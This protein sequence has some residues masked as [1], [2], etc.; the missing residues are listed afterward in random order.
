MRSYYRVMLGK[1]SLYAKECVE[2]GFIGTDYG[3]RQDLTEKLPEDWREFNREFIPIYQQINNIQSK[4]SAGLACGAL[5]TVSKGIREGDIV[6]S[7]DGHSHY[8]VGEVD[9]EYYYES[10]GNLPHRRKVRWYPST[11]DRSVMSEALR[12]SAGSVGTVSNISGYASE[13]EVLIGTAPAD[14]VTILA[15]DTSTEVAAAK[16]EEAVAFKMEKY[17]EQFLIENWA[18]TPLGDQYEIYQGEGDSTGQQY[19]TETGP[20]DIL[21]ISK[22]KKTLLVV[23]LKKGRASDVVVGQI[24]RYMGWVKEELANP[25]QAV[26]GVIIALEDDKRI[27]HALSM[28]PAVAFYRYKITFKLDPVLN[29]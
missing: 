11:I 6:L 1:S 19:M 2:G 24:L 8:H 9:S 12:N 21:A 22:D 7:P 18:Q 17:L 16:V 14:S 27:R 15:G 5:W 26:K 23:E 4:V 13:L 28:V 25:D 3:I 20:L 10:G 29:Q